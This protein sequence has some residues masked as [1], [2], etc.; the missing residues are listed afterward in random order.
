MS[1]DVIKGSSQHRDGSEHGTEGKKK[2]FLSSD[3]G[4]N[5][6]SFFF[7]LAETI[8]EKL[9][10]DIVQRYKQ[11]QNFSYLLFIFFVTGIDAFKS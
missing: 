11:K 3:R 2:T 4:R 10:R 6:E 9:S 8:P 5:A 1:I 7:F